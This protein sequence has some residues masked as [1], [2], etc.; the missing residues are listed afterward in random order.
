MDF[1]AIEAD[2]K[3]WVS[4]LSEIP[5]EW[6]RQPHKVHTGPFIMA[7]IETITPIGHDEPRWA[8]NDATGKLE[9]SMVGNRRVTLRLSFR[10]FSQIGS[11]AAR[12]YAERFRGRTQSSTSV[13]TVHGFECIGQWGTG[14]LIESN[15]RWSGRWVSQADMN[16]TL[17]V[18]SEFFNPDYTGGFIKTVNVE[19]QNYIVDRFGTPVQDNL[20]NPLVPSDHIEITVTIP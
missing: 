7:Y 2:L 12:Q 3:T 1:D 17:G 13:D 14:D 19:G 16:V 10:T 4:G 11:G 5:V 18:R 8:Y 20:G 9:E 6:G 15:Y